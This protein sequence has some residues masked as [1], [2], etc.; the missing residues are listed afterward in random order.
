VSARLGLPETRTSVVS[1][2]ETRT[3]GLHG[4]PVA[5]TASTCCSAA[6]RATSTS[7]YAPGVLT[8]SSDCCSSA[9]A[10]S[11]AALASR[12]SGLAS[13]GPGL[14]AIAYPPLQFK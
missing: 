12:P 2:K 4:L 13:E 6:R 9:A 5:T 8:S 10:W 7:R 3:G 1:R 14:V 11:A